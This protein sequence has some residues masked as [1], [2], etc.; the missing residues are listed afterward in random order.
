MTSEVQEKLKISTLDLTAFSGIDDLEAISE[1]GF[2]FI[3][4]E[5]LKK[6]QK[7]WTFSNCQRDPQCAS[8]IRLY[9]K[10]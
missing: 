6:A 2:E 8:F 10:K 9:F 4:R 3:I 1:D 5:V 7:G